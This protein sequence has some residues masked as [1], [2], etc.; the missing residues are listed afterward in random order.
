MQLI[1]KPRTIV[2][3]K[4][5]SIR[6]EGLVPAEIY[7]HEISNKHISVASKEF[8]NLFKEAGLTSVITLVVGKEKIPAVITGIQK[9]PITEKILCIDFHQIKMGE[10]IE[11]TI[12]IKFTGTAPALKKGF[13]LIKVLDEIE[14]RALPEKIPHEIEVDLSNLENLDQHIAVKDL[15]VEK[16]IKLIT[17]PETIIA[18]ISEKEKEQEEEE[19]ITSTEEKTEKKE[20]APQNKK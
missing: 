16:E 2:G 12:P 6:R 14:V 11:T 18:T 4:V 13:L 17:P 10:K 7:G 1:A 8:L 5:K 15:N 9:H 3:K 20:T 19:T